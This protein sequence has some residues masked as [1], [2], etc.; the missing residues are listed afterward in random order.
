MLTI[1]Q[2]NKVYQNRKDII[3]KANE[4]TFFVM[5]GTLKLPAKLSGNKLEY[6]VAYSGNYQTQIS[7]KLAERIAQGECKIIE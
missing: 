7:W 2:E 3:D 6:P 1:E 5:F 4:N